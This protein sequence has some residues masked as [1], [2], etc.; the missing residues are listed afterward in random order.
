MFDIRLRTDQEKEEA[1]LVQW[2][3]QS[4]KAGGFK[5]SSSEWTTQAAVVTG[6]GD[7]DVLVLREYRS[8]SDGS[9]PLLDHV[10]LI[11]MANPNPASDCGSPENLVINC[12]FE[13]NRVPEGSMLRFEEEHV[14][15]WHSY[16]RTTLELWGNHFNSVPASDGVV[17][18]ELDNAKTG[19]LDGIYQL[20][21]TEKG[22]YLSLIHI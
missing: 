6:T 20:I 2:N 7:E 13:G 8:H 5:T 4:P 3:G 1:V 15:G 11:P 19:A 10:R 12:S 22:Q 21:P 18:L 9:G 17:Y 14:P 16:K